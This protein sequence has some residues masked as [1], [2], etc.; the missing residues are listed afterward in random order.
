M[1]PDPRGPQPWFSLALHSSLGIPES[2]IP[3][4]L[5]RPS[6]GS[7]D[8][9]F[10]S[11]SLLPLR[12]CSNSRLGDSVSLSDKGVSGSRTNDARAPTDAHDPSQRRVTAASTLGKVSV[13]P[14]APPQANTDGTAWPG[15]KGPP[16]ERGWGAGTGAPAAG[17]L[18]NRWQPEAAGHAPELGWGTERLRQNGGPHSQ[19][20]GNPVCTY[21]APAG[22]GGHRSSP[23]SRTVALSH[24]GPSV[25]T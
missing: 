23:A 3:A 1:R 13:S 4:S 25:L 21:Q 2:G 6:P 5:H 19:E 20:E 9:Q 18:G 17:T 10:K 24:R 22:G 7:L 11:G 14:F 16:P 12:P 8:T 15:R